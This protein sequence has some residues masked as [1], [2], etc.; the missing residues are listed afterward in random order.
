MARPKLF[1]FFSLCC[2]ISRNIDLLREPIPFKLFYGREEL[3]SSLFLHF[4]LNHGYIKANSNIN[5]F[6][7]TCFFFNISVFS[8][9]ISMVNCKIG[10]KMAVSFRLDVT[11]AFFIFVRKNILFFFLFLFFFYVL[12]LGVS[13]CSMNPC[14]HGGECIDEENGSFTCACANGYHGATCDTG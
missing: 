11:V 14:R 8:L 13:A 2:F 1:F 12:F 3:E 5:C 10:V 9:F 4:L 7:A 6:P